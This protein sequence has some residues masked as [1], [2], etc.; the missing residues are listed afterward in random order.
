MRGMVVQ[1]HNSQ[2]KKRSYKN[3]NEINKNWKKIGS[4]FYVIYIFPKLY[5]LDY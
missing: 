3:E 4:L 1:F 2:E 5:L